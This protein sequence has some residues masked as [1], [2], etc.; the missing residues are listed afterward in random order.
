MVF[1]KTKHNTN[2]ND[3]TYNVIQSI[4]KAKH[5]YKN[6]IIQAHPD[7]HPSNIDFATQ[8][9]ELINANRFNYRELLK[10]EERIMKELIH[11]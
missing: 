3:E 5:L 10:L 1:F 4:S 11:E 2:L 7:K 9:T 8:L 6:L